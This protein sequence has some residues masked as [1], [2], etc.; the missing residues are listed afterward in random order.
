MAYSF[1]TYTASGST[2]TFTI[3]FGY[4][5]EADIHVYVDGD[6]ADQETLVFPSTGQI[7][8]PSTPSNGESV[9]V[10]R[11]TNVQS[12]VSVFNSPALLHGRDINRVLLQLLYVTQEA[13]DVGDYTQDQFDTLLGTISAA[14]G[15]SQASA[16][17]ANASA[18]AA[19]SGA[20][21]ATAAKL[22]AELA[23]A[24]AIAAAASAEGVGGPVSSTNNALVQFDGTDGQQLKQATM[25]G[26]VKLTAG[27]P[28]AAEAGTDFQAAD[29]NTAKTNVKQSFT[30]P[31]KATPQALTHNTAWD[32]DLYQA[33]TGAIN[34]SNFTV[35]NPS[36]VPAAGTYVTMTFVWS[37]AH[38]LAFGNLY[39]GITGITWPSTSGKEAH[40]T[41]R[42]DGTYL[43]KVG[44]DLDIGN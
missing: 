32:G 1:E 39:K 19:T 26:L 15:S 5:Q 21:D 6:E 2:D 3:P 22:A 14:V 8:L 41:F 34:G 38:T 7:K 28:S 30:R 12:L 25:N 44:Y 37:S 33:L 23:A 42:S 43:K 35:A 24:Q 16:I 36:P 29:S 27:V 40:V 11:I 10:Q 18:S 4:I 20:T 31:Q 9:K 13:F 17:S